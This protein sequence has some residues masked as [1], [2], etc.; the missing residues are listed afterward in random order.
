MT[1][2]ALKMSD[3]AMET[4]ATRAA[5]ILVANLDATTTTE[6]PYLTV[7]EAAEYLCSKPQRV[8]DL[9]SSRRLTR[10]KV[11]SRVLV[12]R[13]ELDDYLG[14]GASKLSQRA[15]SRRFPGR[16][17]HIFPRAPS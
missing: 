16:I 14:R 7:Q 3:Y 1:T 9:L 10:Y 13:A 15:A 5:Q 11:G 2:V 8:Y 17:R 4:I 6:M 12:L